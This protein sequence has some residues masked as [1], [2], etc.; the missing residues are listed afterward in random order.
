[1]YPIVERNCTAFIFATAVV[2]LWCFGVF[3]YFRLDIFTFFGMGRSCIAAPVS[4]DYTVDFD[5]QP[6]MFM[7]SGRIPVGSEV[8]FSHKKN[9]TKSRWVCKDGY[10]Y[11]S[12]R[13]I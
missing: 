13:L 3:M 1:M 2:M 9:G 4:D 12:S 7:D 6:D 5:E 11:K 8:T 10:F